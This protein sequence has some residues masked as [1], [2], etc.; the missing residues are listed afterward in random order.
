MIK[1]EKDN[2]LRIRPQDLVSVKKMG[3]IYEICYLKSF[4]KGQ[5][6]QLIDKDHYMIMSSGEVLECNHIE[7]RS[8]S[9]AQVAQSLKRLRDYINTNVVYPKNCKWITLTY[10]QEDKKPM[11]DTLRLYKD[12]E[13]FMKR[14]RYRFHK[15]QL[16]YIVA[17]EPQASGSW[18]AHLILIFDT[19][20][21]Y[22]SNKEI[23]RLWQQGFTK[24]QKLNDIDN[25]GAYLT[26]YLGDMEFT[27]ENICTLLNNGLN[28]SELVLKDVNQIE[29]IELKE[30]KSFI[31]G[32]R[33]YLYPPNFNLYRC[34]RGIKKPIKELWQYSVIKEKAGLTL[35][36]YS[37]GIKLT[38]TDNTY[39]NSIVYEYYNTKR[40][41]NSN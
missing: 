25:V 29:G 39:N 22:I 27:K 1:I 28:G 38:D 15:Y 20:A 13:K 41:T 14:L 12:F 19:I 30:P 7:N 6:I 33:L 36:T 32:G 21:P 8:Q 35:P 9:K 23:E 18:H 4:N 11:T 10:R 26:A 5:T 17:C 40:I 37:K 3:S 2:G 31:K 24:T 34:S 16:E